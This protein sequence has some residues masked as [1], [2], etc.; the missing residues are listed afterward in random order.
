MVKITVKIA[1]Q[2]TNNEVEYEAMIAGLKLFIT[3]EVTII[4]ISSDSQLVVRKIM[5]K[6]RTSDK[7]MFLYVR[8]IKIYLS[9]GVWKILTE[10]K[11][12]WQTHWPNWPP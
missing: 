11:M 3:L 6:F 8:K 5:G 9:N 1:F 2:A 12:K 10:W 7:R 4:D